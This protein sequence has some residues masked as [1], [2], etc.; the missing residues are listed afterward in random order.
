MKVISG[1]LK[2]R[3]VEGHDI[4]GTR[5]TMDRLKESLF[6]IIQNQVKDTICLDLFAGSGSLGIEALSNGARKC[7]FNDVNKIC[8]NTINRNLSN[9]NIKEKA[10]VTCKDYQKFIKDITKENIKFDLIF[11]DPPYKKTFLNDLIKNIVDSNILNQEGLIIC[12]VDDNYLEEIPTLEIIKQRKYGDKYI[13]I[14]KN[15]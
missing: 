14:Y 12:E 6:A 10:V 13:T 9:F 15:N 11:L 2:G 4:K 8:V 5:P 7:Y 1:I 3:T